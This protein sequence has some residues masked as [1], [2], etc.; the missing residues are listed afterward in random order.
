MSPRTVDVAHLLI[1]L[2]ALLG[3]AH[4]GGYLFNAIRQ[5]PVIG[6]ILG[7]LCLGPT[8]LGQLAPGAQHW[9]FPSTGP[10][11]GVLGALYNIGLL[12]LVYLTGTEMRGRRARTERRTVVWVAVS[13]LVLPFLF[14]LLVATAVG[15]NGLAG[16]HGSPAT[17]ALVFGM[18]V[19]ITSIP[20]ISRIM[21]DLGVI[22]TAFARIVL[23][24]AVVEDILLYVVLA[25]TLGMAQART[26]DSYGLP[27]LLGIDTVGESVAYF[28]LAPL[29]FMLPFAWRGRMLFDRLASA[30]FNLIEGR[31]PAAFRMILV[32]VMCVAAIGLGIDPVFGALMA[33][34]C[35]SGGA[36]E[37]A[38]P[39]P[40]GGGGSGAALREMTLAFF[41]P[42]YFAIV[43]LRLDLARHLDPVFFC[44]FLAFA[45]IVK[46]ISVWLGA[47][48][49][50][51]DN[52]S[53]ANIAIAMNARG[54]PGIVLASTS[55]AAG[56]INENL[57]T[58]LVLLSLVTSQAAGAWLGRIA[59]RGLP[60]T[61]PEKPRP[62]ESDEAE[63]AA[64][65][66]A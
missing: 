43:G 19:A 62:Q 30:R 61:V 60:L 53:A 51:Q 48:L 12:L 28:T 56:V 7:G 64:R 21:I 26:G 65:I 3:A 66:P 11:P 35:A 24:V 46:S 63:D 20:V 39:L 27:K 45:C 5:P 4:I 52:S 47:R 22:D 58:A 57:F 13:G 32:F 34:L 44:W 49:A 38:N 17:L 23:A 15:L 41:V 54:G 50:G 29:V 42:V 33:G 31:A 25:V 2:V 14:G 6:E 9:L 36:R 16:P 1:A 55:F 10:T 40:A 8:V 37:G 18:A 59:R